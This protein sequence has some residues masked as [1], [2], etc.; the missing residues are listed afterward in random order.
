[1]HEMALAQGIV[2]I[3]EEHAK[4]LGF[5]R[6]RRLR[7]AIGDLSHVEP[8]ALAFGFDAAS[9]G[10]AA[11]GAELALQRVPGRATCLDCGGTFPLAN[12]AAPCPE[13]AGHKII[14]IEGEEMR[15]LDMEIA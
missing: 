9:R 8:R 12:R 5:P 15:V 11:E 7:V 1:M 3:V 6:I 10:T 4:R 13:C 2:E 14:V